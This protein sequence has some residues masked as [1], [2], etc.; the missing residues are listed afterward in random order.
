MKKLIILLV[1]F[2]MLVLCNAA[3][4]QAVTLSFDPDFQGVLLGNQVDVNVVISG[5]GD[6]EAPSLG[7][8]DFDITFDPTIL[9]LSS[10]TFGSYLGD[11][12]PFL[13]ETS[14]GFTD[15]GTGTVNIWEVSWLDANSISGPSYNPPYLEFMQPES[16]ALATLTFDT[17]SFGTSS[18]DISSYDLGD[19]HGEDMLTADLESG[20]INV[21]PVPEPATLF[22]L[23]TGLAGIGFLRKKRMNR[24]SS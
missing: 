18:L 12:D 2:L 5:L 4:S 16:F 23:G 19:A 20:N 3:V 17:R 10:I 13:F 24:V 7:T 6:G 1:A 21:V 15:Y 8:F 22:L 11:P 9:A 14:L